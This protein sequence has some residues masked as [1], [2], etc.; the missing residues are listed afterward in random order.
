[1]GEG[2]RRRMEDREER[3]EREERR[4]RGGRNGSDFIGFGRYL[5]K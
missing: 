2:G 1:V 4:A 3:E 5:K